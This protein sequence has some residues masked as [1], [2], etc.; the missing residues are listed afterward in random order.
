MGSLFSTK[1][2][3]VLVIIQ[4]SQHIMMFQT[5]ISEIIHYQLY[6]EGMSRKICKVK[7]NDLRYDQFYFISS[8]REPFPLSRITADNIMLTFLIKNIN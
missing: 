1:Q 3:L 2:C 8:F 5:N 7:I 4:Q 6:L